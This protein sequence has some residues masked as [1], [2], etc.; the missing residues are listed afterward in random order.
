ML[1]ED[2]LYYVDDVLLGVDPVQD[3][4]PLPARY[5]SREPVIHIK[6]VTHRDQRRIQ[7]DASKIPPFKVYF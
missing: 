5:P 6:L 3:V 4:V 1:M 7:E 2:L